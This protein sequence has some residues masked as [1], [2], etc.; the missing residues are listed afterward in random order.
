MRKF[1][2]FVDIVMAV[3]MI[4][5]MSYQ[6]TGTGIYLSQTVFAPLL[7]MREAYLVRPFHVAAGAWGTIFVSI[8]AGMHL[9]LP[10]KINIF[11]MMA[12][13]LLVLAGSAAFAALDMPSRLIFQDS[14]MY[15]NYPGIM[16][17]AVSASR[18]SLHLKK[19]L[20]IVLVGCRLTALFHPVHG[21]SA[22]WPAEPFL[23]W[24]SAGHLLPIR[25]K[26]RRD[27]RKNR[28]GSDYFRTGYIAADS[29]IF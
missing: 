1:R 14:G 20:R 24:E 27:R 25:D 9:R 13:I 29:H 8:H 15:W 21:E 6:A 28:S 2:K 12:F 5:V 4:G 23:R 16:L 10:E 19:M 7:G 22:V 3:L 11:H 17:F 18:V 26:L